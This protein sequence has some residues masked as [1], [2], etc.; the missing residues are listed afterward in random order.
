MI[1]MEKLTTSPTRR[2][3]TTSRESA[4]DLWPVHVEE[5]VVSVLVALARSVRENPGMAL[6]AAVAAGF[7][8]GF[9]LRRI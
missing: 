1:S 2:L 6:G 7:A 3:H 4:L 9:G 8:V 5:V